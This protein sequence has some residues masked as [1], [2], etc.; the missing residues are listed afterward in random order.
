MES[1][2]FESSSFWIGVVSKS[3]FPMA[4]L[5]KTC[6]GWVI[7][8]VN[9]VILKRFNCFEW[10]AIL[11]EWRLSFSSEP[12]SFS[13]GYGVFQSHSPKGFKAVEEYQHWLHIK[14]MD[15]LPNSY[16]IYFPSGVPS[17]SFP[18]P[19]LKFLCTVFHSHSAFL[20]PCLPSRPHAPFFITRPLFFL[21]LATLYPPLQSHMQFFFPLSQF[22]SCP[23]FS[24]HPVWSGSQRSVWSAKYSCWTPA[25]W[26]CQ[27]PLQEQLA[28]GTLP[29]WSAGPVCS[30]TMQW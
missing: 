5:M 12:P 21:S 9:L 28:R 14:L 24:P 18:L 17:V 22:I 19:F 26:R 10:K 1:R 6:G 30:D 4:K 3:V 20:C 8:E 15:S 11:A 13:P 29:W 27:Q 7:I 25:G 23:L 2:L 16:S